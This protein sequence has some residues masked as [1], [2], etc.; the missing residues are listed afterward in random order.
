MQQLIERI[1]S[2]VNMEIKW[3]MILIGYYNNEFINV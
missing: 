2:E 3:T 1:V